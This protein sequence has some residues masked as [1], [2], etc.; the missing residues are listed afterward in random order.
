MLSTQENER[1]TR[2]GRGTPM[3]ELMR[4]Y[5]QPVAVTSELKSRRTMPVR[6]L[7]ED[8]V[9][10][11]DRS[12]T[13]G[14]IARLCPHRR[15]DLSYGIPEET[16]LRCMYHGW[17]F[18]ETG[19]CIEQPFEETVH[20]DGRFKEK[21]RVDAYP[22]Q[23]LG[24]LMWAYLGPQPAPLLP[25][26]DLLVWDNVLRDIGTTVLPC[27][28]LQCMENSLDPVHTEWLHVY[29]TNHVLERE[30]RIPD[31]RARRHDPHTRVGFDIYNHGIVK[32]RVLE[33]TTESDSE[34]TIGHPIIF[35]NWLGGTTGFQIRVPIDDTHTWHLL[36]NVYVPP[37]GVVIPEQQEIPG[38]DVPFADQDGRALV[39]FVIGQDTVAWWTQGAIAD[40]TK[41]K[42]GESDVGIILYRRFL[43][44][45]MQVVQDGG[46]PVNVFRDPA[47]NEIIYTFDEHRPAGSRYLTGRRRLGGE[48]QSI[49]MSGEIDPDTGALVRGPTGMHSPIA[50]R[51]QEIFAKA[52]A[53]GSTEGS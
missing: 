27:N 32:K 26:W 41:E 28:W 33:S 51:A 25:R 30:G 6:I 35:P 24:G 5:W 53:S 13:Y 4:R 50:R 44:E 7:G 48:F 43:Q 49:A 19:Q 23:E 29:L 20:P 37:E 8:L 17:M 46:D 47:E 15:V 34:W 10:Y 18:D 9:L 1:L 42:L 31:A 16:G 40:R 52:A 39:N 45:Q 3:G 38:Y 14:L 12:G 11:E 21:L 36:Y 22:V 2:V